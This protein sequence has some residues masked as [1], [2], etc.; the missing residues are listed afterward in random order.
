MAQAVSRIKSMPLDNHTPYYTIKPRQNHVIR[1]R[2]QVLQVIS[3]LAWISHNGDDLILKKGDT[4]TLTKGGDAVI[5]VSGLFGKP[6]QYTL[7]D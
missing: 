6:V 4:V 1:A 3:G 5:M 7:R 2:N